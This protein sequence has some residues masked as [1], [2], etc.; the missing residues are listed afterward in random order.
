[1]AARQGKMLDPGMLLLEA[2]VQ[3]FKA[4]RALHCWVRKEC[5]CVCVRQEYVEIEV[6][7]L[8]TFIIFFKA[9]Q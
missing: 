6:T 3:M 4:G 1:M 7:M 5:V 9:G 2:N 8:L